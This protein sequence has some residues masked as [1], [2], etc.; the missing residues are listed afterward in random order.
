M[1]VE[2]K[3]WWEDKHSAGYISHHTA[4]WA[5]LT[6]LFQM[7]FKAQ[8]FVL[9]TTLHH[10]SPNQANSPH[11]HYYRRHSVRRNIGKSTSYGSSITTTSLWMGA[12]NRRNKQND[13]MK[14]FDQAKEGRKTHVEPSKQTFENDKSDE[15]VKDRPKLT[16][17]DAKKVAVGL[18]DEE[19]KDRNDRKRFDEILRGNGVGI[20]SDITK[21][22][23]SAFMTNAQ[24]EAEYTSP[25]ASVCCCQVFLRI[26]A[27]PQRKP[28]LR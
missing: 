20:I 21:R 26:Q 27:M 19:M 7:I 13:L 6:L 24:E 22:S 16:R 25:C 28:D 12:F 8:S 11:Q 18:T 2:H 5:V 17:D 9:Y 1:N 15:V 3:S 4:F 10:T 14:K 23:S